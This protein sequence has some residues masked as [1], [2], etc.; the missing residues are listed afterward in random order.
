M[1]ENFLP[2]HNS[3]NIVVVAVSEGTVRSC[4]IA[5][6][7]YL[8]SHSDPMYDLLPDSVVPTA[9]GAVS[10]VADLYGPLD[11]SAWADV[12]DE[13]CVEL[14]AAWRSSFRWTD[15]EDELERDR[16]PGTE[17]GCLLTS[18]SAGW[19]SLAYG[20]CGLNHSNFQVLG[21]RL[22][23]CPVNVDVNCCDLGVE[24]D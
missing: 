14:F 20:C 16:A 23:V 6:Q 19:L 13:S 18:N 22:W 4:V 24:G 12:E 9:R 3:C 11:Y 21:L 7:S 10:H 1:G 17:I 8:W 2:H 5:V 15:S